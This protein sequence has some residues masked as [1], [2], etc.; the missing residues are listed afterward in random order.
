M[1]KRRSSNLRDFGGSNP[2]RATEL[3]GPFGPLSA[4]VV[5]L[6]RDCEPRV[7]KLRG[8]DERFDSFAAHK[9]EFIKYEFGEFAMPNMAYFEPCQL[10]G[11]NLASVCCD[12]IGDQ[13][14][15]L[16]S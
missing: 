2:F 5:F 12:G 16:V 9:I 13:T 10:S 8:G 15:N 6:V 3:N 7:K 4:W 14:F 11:L 1:E